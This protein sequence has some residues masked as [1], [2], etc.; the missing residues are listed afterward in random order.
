MLKFLRKYRFSSQFAESVQ[1]Q[2]S[3]AISFINENNPNE[4]ISD[5]YANLW[6]NCD[7]SVQIKVPSIEKDQNINLYFSRFKYL[8]QIAVGPFRVN[9]NSSRE[10][11]D[12]LAKL[13]NFQ[14]YLY[15]F[16][17]AGAAASIQY[18]PKTKLEH[19]NIIKNFVIELCRLGFMSPNKFIPGNDLGTDRLDMGYISQLYSSL[20]IKKDNSLRG[21]TTSKPQHMGGAHGSEDSMGIGISYILN[22]Y[23]NNLEI[24]KKHKM[25][26]GVE[27]KE[28][29]IQ[30]FGEAGSSTANVLAEQGAKIIGIVEK[31]GCIFNPSGID[32]PQFI[33][34]FDACKKGEASLK[35]YPGGSFIEGDEV[36]FR[37]CD[38]FIPAYRESTVNRFFFHVNSEQIFISTNSRLL[39]RQPLE[40]LLMKLKRK[41]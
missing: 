30:G 16:P 1:S 14:A 7:Y 40:H 38:I 10:I 36:S 20:F 19:S 21:C 11:N 33:K 29:I 15:D 3:K 24:L 27:G 17:Y 41:F 31:E 9:E 32:I 8:N 39:L 5:F 12:S 37:Q 34:Y 35:N 28:V 18:S 25:V 26:P 22:H 2:T 6:S 13:Y 4:Q 23:L